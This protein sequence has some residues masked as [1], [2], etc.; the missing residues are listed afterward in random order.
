MPYICKSLT[1]YISSNRSHCS[2]V[3]G[4]V[5]Q[6][7]SRKVGTSFAVVPSGLLSSMLSTVGT[8]AAKV[9]P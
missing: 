4:A 6:V 9:M 8:P 1:P 3:S 5:L 2:S 7:I